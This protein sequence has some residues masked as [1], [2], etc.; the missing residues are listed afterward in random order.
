MPST[1]KLRI[2]TLAVPFLTL[3][4]PARAEIALPGDHAFPESIAST[5]DGTLYVSSPGAG[6]VLRVEPGQAAK[7]W[8][9]P[10]AYGTRSTF[11]VLADETSGMLWVCSND[12]SALGVAGPSTVK[13][14]FLKGFDLK[15]GAGKVSAQLPGAKALCNDM[16]I[17]PDGS[18][19]VTNSL[20]PEVLRLKPG[21]KTLEVWAQSPMFQPPKQGAGL[22]GIVFGGDGNL[23]VDLFN[24]AKLFRIDVKDGAPGKV[25]EL[26]PS[27]GLKLTDALRAAEGSSFL[28]IE[29]AGS[30]DRVTVDGDAAKVDTLK[31]GM[32]GPTGVT[33]VGTKAYVSEGQLPKLFGHPSGGPTLPFK[34]YEVPLK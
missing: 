7:T 16:A 28:M 23:Y 24:D 6:G 22:D 20:A 10:G 15:S 27:R 34:V 9:A 8:V 17:A 3:A 18:V 4:A 14:A 13:G 1:A 30:L 11:G 25:T 32:D 12:I 5:V 33:T 29:G 19:L 26:K 21:G 2:L 31:Q